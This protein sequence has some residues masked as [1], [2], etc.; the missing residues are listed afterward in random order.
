MLFVVAE[1]LGRMYVWLKLT[2]KLIL[3][4]SPSSK[5]VIIEYVLM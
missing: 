3:N 2:K 4:L 5:Y 1:G